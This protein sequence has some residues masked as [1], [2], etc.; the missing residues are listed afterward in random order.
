MTTEDLELR[1]EIETVYQRLDR[2]EQKLEELLTAEAREETALELRLI[3]LA[4]TKPLVADF[5]QKHPGC[6]TSD[7][8]KA[9]ALDPE[10]IVQALHELKKEG[11]IRSGGS[12]GA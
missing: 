8:M 4:E 6:W 12:E 11:L 7:I 9:L 2:L 3:P 5:V 1:K 10:V